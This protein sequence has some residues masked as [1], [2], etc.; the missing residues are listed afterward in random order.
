LIEEEIENSDWLSELVRISLKEL[1]PP[2][3]K[4]KK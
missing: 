2:R 3:S 4:K 1:P